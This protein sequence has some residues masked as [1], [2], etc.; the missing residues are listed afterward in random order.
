M[1]QPLPRPEQSP[2][3]VPRVVDAGDYGESRVPNP[4]GDGDAESD[5]VRPRMARE[6]ADREAQQGLPGP[7]TNMHPYPQPP[8]PG[9]GLPTCPALGPPKKPI[10]LKNVSNHFETF[11]TLHHNAKTKKKKPIRLK[12]VSNHFET[13]D[14]LHHNAKTSANQQTKR[15]HCMTIDYFF[16]KE[17]LQ[18]SEFIFFKTFKFRVSSSSS[19]E[20]FT[21]LLGDCEDE[22]KH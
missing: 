9:P 3:A 12:N 19:S 15:V 1:P 20:L 4:D 5:A 22:N 7:Q 8:A 11:D 14:T 13:F 6:A 2:R 16:S 21:P 17:N 18:C 10:R